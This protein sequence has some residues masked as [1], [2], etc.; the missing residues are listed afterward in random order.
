[1]NLPVGYL[2]GDVA[3]AAHIEDKA[4]QLKGLRWRAAGPGVQ[5]AI[6]QG[7]RYRVSKVDSRSRVK[8]HR[9]RFRAQW[10]PVE[11]G[12]IELALERNQDWAKLAAVSH[13][14]RHR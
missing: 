7:G 11:G 10:I 12:P 13:W 2:R 6:A 8:R 4:L 9:Y 1:M 3:R 5:E 14:K